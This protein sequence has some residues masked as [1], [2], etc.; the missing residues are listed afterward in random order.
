MQRVKFL[1]DPDMTY[2][3]FESALQRNSEAL[4]RLNS[5]LPGGVEGTNT[6]LTGGKI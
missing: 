5:V 3:A 2:T 6:L 1:L 4:Q